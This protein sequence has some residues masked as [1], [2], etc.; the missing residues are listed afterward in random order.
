M[1]ADQLHKDLFHLFL[2]DYLRVFYPDDAPRLKLETITWLEQETFTDVPEGEQQIMDLCA[3]VETVDEDYRLLAILIELQEKV[4]RDFPRRMY[5]YWNWTEERIRLPVWPLALLPTRVYQ[6]QGRLVYA[7]SR[8]GRPTLRF[9]FDYVALRGLQSPTYLA[10][11]VPFASA[12]AARMRPGRM[13]PAEHKLAC[14][15]GIAGHGLDPAREFLLTNYVETYLP[16]EDPAEVALFEELTATE[17]DEE[18]QTMLVTWADRMKME[19]KIEGK[20]SLLLLQLREKFPN[21]PGTVENCLREL[22][23][24]TELDRLSVRLLKARTLADLGLE[25]MAG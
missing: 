19:G 11:E 17:A 1:P 7:L 5:R 14:M 13:R 2:P 4:R 18:T 24:D 12:L 21:L 6:G 9:E 10:R 20:R 15:Q 16:L 25:S 3:R 23:D 8:L 22:K